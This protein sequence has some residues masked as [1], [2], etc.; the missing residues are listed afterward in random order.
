MVKITR[1]RKYP[2][3]IA[4]KLVREDIFLS[5]LIS[6]RNAEAF[7]RQLVFY[8]QSKFL[9]F[10]EIKREGNKQLFKTIIF[11]TYLVMERCY[12]KKQTL[13]S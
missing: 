8:L 13:R 1:I 4:I 3:V 7:K 12:R 11:S 2:K 9:S 5:F 6:I 10:L